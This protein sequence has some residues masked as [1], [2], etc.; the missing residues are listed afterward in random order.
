MIIQVNNYDAMYMAAVM[1]HHDLRSSIPDLKAKPG[2]WMRVPDEAIVPEI[3]DAE[4]VDFEIMATGLEVDH[5]EKGLAAMRDRLASIT[6][7]TSGFTKAMEKLTTTA[8]SIDWGKIY[9]IEDKG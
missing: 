7:D 6:I 8:S 2:F 3:L 5:L 1:E 4:G 9:D